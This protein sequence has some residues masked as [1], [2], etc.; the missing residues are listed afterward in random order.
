MENRGIGGSQ[1]LEK[2]SIAM[3][4]TPAPKLSFQASDV[5]FTG[6]GPGHRLQPPFADNLPDV[7]RL[8][9]QASIRRP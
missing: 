6:V 1:N 8:I 5:A 2:Y 7:Q 3:T 4:S 9:K